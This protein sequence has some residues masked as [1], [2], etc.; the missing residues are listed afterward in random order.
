MCPVKRT[1]TSE[2][3]AN[4][5]TIGGI[6]GFYLR[7]W[8]C[9]SCLRLYQPG[10]FVRLYSPVCWPALMRSIKWNLVCCIFWTKF[11]DNQNY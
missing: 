1:I 3:E 8:S 5:I 10:E 6:C 9:V 7:D 2:S 4:L 11:S